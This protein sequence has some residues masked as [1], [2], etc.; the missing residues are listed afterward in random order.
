MNAYGQSG[1]KPHQVTRLLHKILND[2]HIEYP[3]MAPFTVTI[4]AWTQASSSRYGT[5][6]FEQAFAALR[7]TE[8]DDKCRTTRVRPHTD[9]FDTL[10]R[11]LVE[12]AATTDR[13][14][15]WANIVIESMHD[16]NQR[17]DDFVRPTVQTYQL[18]ITASVRA[19]DYWRADNLLHRLEQH[20]TWA[21]QRR[22]QTSSDIATSS[23]QSKSPPLLHPPLQLD[24]A[25]Y[26]D[27]LRLYAS[28]D[29]HNQEKED[30]S[31][32]LAAAQRA[33][34]LLAHVEHLA[35]TKTANSSSTLTTMSY[36]IVLQ[37]WAQCNDD[38]SNM[39]AARAWRLYQEMKLC[40]IALD[41]SCYEALL[42]ILQADPMNMECLS[43]ADMIRHEMMG[44][45][46]GTATPTTVKTDMRTR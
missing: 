17:G 23:T 3:T 41:E 7:L 16:F 45:R 32:R 46:S 6:A 24:I 36:A 30:P 8:H 38:G 21:Q 29:I 43:K 10:L 40:H 2:T 19:R 28:T 27:V 39:A 4:Q 22:G 25:F 12:H 20:A 1:D 9:T 37:A 13:A 35:K 33:D 15:L 44:R 14:G 26:N 31:V 18:A 34:E 5:I 11:C 42:H